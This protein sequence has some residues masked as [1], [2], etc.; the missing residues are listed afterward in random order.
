MPKVLD[1][2]E[3]VETRRPARPT[4]PPTRPWL[5]WV[6][7]MIA[8][9]AVVAV[10][11]IA[12]IANSD[13]GAAET[14]APIATTIAGPTFTFTPAVTVDVDAPLGFGTEA[15]V[16]PMPTTRL[17]E[18]APGAFVQPETTFM[19]EAT[20]TPGLTVI[21]PPATI[22]WRTLD[23]V[24]ADWRISPEYPSLIRRDVVPSQALAPMAAEYEL[25]LAEKLLPVYPENTVYLEQIPVREVSQTQAHGAMADDYLEF[26][27]GKLTVV[28]PTHPDMNLPNPVAL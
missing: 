26:L 9:A 17:V 20:V 5:K 25:Y 15:T 14:P 24:V 7:W 3:V 22:F 18:Q 12:V 28:E 6:V 10:V 1:R 11:V 4:P 8:A 27:A 21:E 13:D 23:Q 19:E 16:A 2:P